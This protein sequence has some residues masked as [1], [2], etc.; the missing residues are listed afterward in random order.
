M[1]DQVPSIPVQQLP[2]LAE[3]RSVEEDW[4]GST[5][6]AKRRKLQNR[7]NQR[8]RRRRQKN[9]EQSLQQNNAVPTMPSMLCSIGR[10]DHRELLVKFAE[11]ALESYRLGIPN[12][13]HLT[14]TI[15]FNIFHAF[16]RNAQVLGFDD[17]WL[18][19]EAVSPFNKQ[20][21]LQ[22]SA[23]NHQDY[24]VSMRP[25][26]LQ[27]QVEHHPWIDFFPCP[28]MRDNLLQVVF[29]HGED[30]VDEDALCHDIT[31]GGATAGIG[32]AAMI[33]W[34]DSWSPDGWEV[35]EMFLKKW[36]WLL[37]GCVELQTSTNTW[38]N[39]RGLSKL[40]F[41]GC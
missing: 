17:D 9:G 33:T 25:T 29:E 4:T 19:Y 6:P 28:R 14:D 26:P 23:P 39:R 38:R 5:G 2:Q 34:A 10:P 40:Q 20:G 24:P 7:L 11:Q 16:V 27:V 35:T 3:L 32:S 36:S 15:R 12:V 22:V 8:A 18:T 30:A 37:H 13:I 21:P 41:P 1:A 31:D